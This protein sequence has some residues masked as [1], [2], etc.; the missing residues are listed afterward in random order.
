MSNAFG[1]VS[2]AATAAWARTM[3]ETMRPKQAGILTDRDVLDAIT[4]LTRGKQ[5]ERV[6]IDRQLYRHLLGTGLATA[7]SLTP[8]P[9]FLT[10]VTRQ[11]LRI[12]REAFIAR[13]VAAKLNPIPCPF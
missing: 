3:A 10:T 7:D 9:N 13:R 6:Q 2:A 4:P 5:S 12:E 11:K 1:N 8:N